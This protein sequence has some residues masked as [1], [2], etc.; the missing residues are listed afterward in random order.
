MHEDKFEKQVREKMDQLGFDPTDGVWTQV[1]YEINKEKQRRRSIFWIFFLTG[2]MLAGGAAYLI[3]NNFVPSKKAIVNSDHM[4]AK[5][6]D[7]LPKENILIEKKR[8][9][10][11]IQKNQI[12]E[13]FAWKNIVKKSD[14]FQSANPSLATEETV[15]SA[16]KVKTETEKN[17][18]SETNSAFKSDSPGRAPL[19][20]RGPVENAISKGNTNDVSVNGE[21]TSKAADQDSASYIKTVKTKN[22]ASKK[23]PWAIV[24]TGGAGASNVNQALFQ[25]LNTAGLNYSGYFPA[26]VGSVPVAVNHDQSGTSAGFSFALGMS[27]QRKLSK[28]ISGSVGLGYHYYSTGIH[29]GI[30]V[31]SSLNVYSS[32]GQSARVNSYFINSKGQEYT[33]QYH[34]IELPVNL[35]FQ[36]NK[37]R[38]NPLN[39]E[40]GF[41]LNWLVSSNALHY[42]PYNNV[43]F[44][45]TQLFNKI[46]W[47]AQTAILIGF[48]LRDHTIQVGPQV[49]YGLTSLLKNSSSYPGHLICYGLKF[50]FK[51]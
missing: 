2:C 46:Q 20:P 4:V 22:H 9:N 37:S 11:K 6:Q 12:T 17:A 30:Q 19:I 29:T 34:Y 41:S 35:S 1:D 27:V 23:S 14:F 10:G 39:W 28:R 31:N 45:N 38:K 16:K 3:I 43:Y 44:E 32:L 51:P 24:I 7:V 18:A 26:N 49:Q 5:H 40:G 25:P 50:S 47:D 8:P 21:K 13:H 33:N 48:P 42:D 15:V 36:L